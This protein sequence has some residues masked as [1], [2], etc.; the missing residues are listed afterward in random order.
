[1]FFFIKIKVLGTNSNFLLSYNIQ[2]REKTVKK[3]KLQIRE[4]T[5]KAKCTHL[6]ECCKNAHI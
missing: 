1:M 4:K 2:I 5:L 3:L 6:I